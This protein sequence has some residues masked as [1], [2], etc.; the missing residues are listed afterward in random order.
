MQH[1][2]PGKVV[3]DVRY[4]AN[5]SSKLR[6]FLWVNGTATLAATKAAIANPQIW[7]QQVPN[8]YYGV[9]SEVA[10]GCGTA[11]TVEAIDLILP[12]S[13]YCSPGGASLVGEYNAPRGHNWYNGLE[14]KATRRVYGAG[15]RG[16]TFQ[17]AYTWS[18][19][20][21]GDGYQ[22]GWPYQDAEQ[23]HWIAGTDRTNVLG[24]TSVWDLPFGKGSL[25]L[26][27]PS[28]PL[29]LLIN[30]WTLSSVVSAQSGTPVGLD[31]GYFYTCSHSFAPD[32]GTSVGQGRWFYA[33]PSCWQNIPQWGLSDL[34]GQ[35]DQVRNPTIANF[36]LSLQK[37]IPVRESVKFLLRLDAFNALNSVLFPG[38]DTNP[39]D[40]PAHYITGT[41]WS[42]FGTVREQ[43]QNFPRVLQVSGKITF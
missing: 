12:L 14:V 21:N 24:I 32:G 27:N 17:L 40:G 3:L 10:G 19:T 35:T 7:N 8:P 20:I 9:A 26:S 6:T 43:Q 30:N 15:S 25:I 18:K 1:E 11:T 2:F 41:G 4:A 39:G 13:Q 23:V 5:Y 33:N 37:S 34:P 29:G 28:G 22:N 16:L 42:G 36:D 38:P 31:T